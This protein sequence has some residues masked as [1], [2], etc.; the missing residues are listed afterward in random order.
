MVIALSYSLTELFRFVFGGN[1]D[2]CG[3]WMDKM[4]SS[5][6]AGN[7]GCPSSPRDGSAVEIV[8]LCYASVRALSLL[9]EKYKYQEVPV[10]TSLEVWADTI[11]ENFDKYFWVGSKAGAEVEPQPHLVN[12]V[13]M[14]K[15]SVGSS[16][17]FTDYQ[18]VNSPSLN[19]KTMH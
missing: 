14:F 19:S 12:T 9:G 8:G 18:L 1:S 10:F 2:N 17:Q 11:R 4:G 13:N 16:G 6:P 3:T 15:D 7:K 5:G